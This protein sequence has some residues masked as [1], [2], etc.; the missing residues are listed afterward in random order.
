MRVPLLPLADWK[1]MRIPVLTV[2]HRD[3]VTLARISERDL[4]DGLTLTILGAELE[5]E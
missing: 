5:P 1:A 4:L 2:T 3:G